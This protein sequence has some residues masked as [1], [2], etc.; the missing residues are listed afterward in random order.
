M[1]IYFLL[2]VLG[3]FRSF[4]ITTVQ[5]E[6][7]HCVFEKRWFALGQVGGGDVNWK[8][9]ATNL[10]W[11][12]HRSKSKFPMQQISDDGMLYSREFTGGNALHYWFFDCSPAF[13]FWKIHMGNWLSLYKMDYFLGISKMMQQFLCRA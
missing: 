7:K 5:L 13:I 4:H 9:V 2:F 8:D 12:R 10:S 3:P 11:L 1:A 6:T